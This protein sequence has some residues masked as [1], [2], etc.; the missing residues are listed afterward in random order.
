[1]L[2]IRKFS[3]QPFTLDRLVELKTLR[4]DMARYLERCVRQRVS[5]LVS[6]GTGSGKTSTLNALGLVIP[7]G[8][9]L[10]T[11]EDFG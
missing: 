9:R 4:P 11:I 7:S 6:G 10:I 2:T 8:E 3:R 5:V 1:M